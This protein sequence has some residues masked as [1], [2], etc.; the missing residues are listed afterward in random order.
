VISPGPAIALSSGREGN[1]T[2]TQRTVETLVGR[3]MTDE[4]FRTEFLGNPTATLDALRSQGLDLSAIE[5]AALAGTDPA[6]WAHATALLDAR[7]QKASLANQPTLRPETD[8]V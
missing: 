4:A 6:L 8:H 7:L 3:L 2:V 5:V 1:L